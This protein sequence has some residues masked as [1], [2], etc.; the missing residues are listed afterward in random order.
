M[1]PFNNKEVLGTWANA[2][3]I[4][5]IDVKPS[6]RLCHRHFDLENDFIYK[7]GKKI[8]IRPDAEPTKFLVSSI[9]T[10]IF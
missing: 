4:A 6:F 7:D 8:R 5:L 10:H 2:M 9:T 3:E 1:V